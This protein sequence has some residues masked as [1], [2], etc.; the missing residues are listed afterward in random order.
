MNPPSFLVRLPTYESSLDQHEEYFIL[1]QDGIEQAIR[2]QDYR[3]IY[4]VPGLYEYVLNDMLQCVSHNLTIDLLEANLRRDGESLAGLSVLE[5]GAGTG[6]VAAGL[7]QRGV[8]TIVGI[9]ILEEAMEAA[10]R[11][12]PG[13]YTRYYAEDLCRLS[14][15]TRREL[16]V[17]A[18]NCLACISAGGCNHIPARAFTAGYN[19]LPDGGWILTNI[20]TSTLEHP[21]TDHD[22]LPRLINQITEDGTFEVYERKTYQH[23]LTVYGKPIMYTAL[24]GRKRA[25][26]V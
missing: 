7:R 16:S 18:F 5:I 22:A 3:A 13:V 4:R 2:L 21:Q 9:D 6:L 20:R 17:V 1:V 8:E 25:A 19:M 23:R 24:V 14:A 15:D 10:E 12:H 26:I 11:D